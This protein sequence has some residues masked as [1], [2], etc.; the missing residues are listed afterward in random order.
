MHS[1]RLENEQDI[2]RGDKNKGAALAAA[3]AGELLSTP[4]INARYQSDTYL[5]WWLLRMAYWQVEDLQ[6]CFTPSRHYDIV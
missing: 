4:R 6:P 5:Y 3:A 1:R 2:L